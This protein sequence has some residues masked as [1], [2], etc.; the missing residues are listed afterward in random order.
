[1]ANPKERHYWTQLRAALTSGLWDSDYPGKEPNN[2]PLK[3]SEL[4]RKFNKHCSGCSDVAELASQTQAL[5]L[6]LAANAS[7]QSLDGNDI[8]PKGPLHLDEECILSEER[9]AE[10]MT[11][12]TA[13]QAINSSNTEVRLYGFTINWL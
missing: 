10:G 8:P 6:L 7:D 11:G 13:L 3:W 2:T 9:V 1:M 4:L 5:S 12:F